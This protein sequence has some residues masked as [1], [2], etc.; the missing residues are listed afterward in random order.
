MTAAD[1][2]RSAGSVAVTLPSGFRVRMVVPPADEIIRQGLSPAAA[3]A[4]VMAVEA[5]AQADPDNDAA[6]VMLDKIRAIAAR[7]VRAVWDDESGDWEPVALSFED[8]A[9]GEF[10]HRDVEALEAIAGH[11]A[12][13]AEVTARSTG[14][15][16]E[17]AGS[18]EAWARFRDDGRSV[19]DGEGGGAV[20]LPAIGPAGDR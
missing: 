1:R 7:S 19:G 10:D 20:V 16:V 9:D 13:P 15:A 5:G 11:R 8:L 3:M 12:T 4:A 2:W 17:E 18:A 6:R 14:E